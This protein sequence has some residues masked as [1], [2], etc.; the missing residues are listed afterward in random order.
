MTVPGQKVVSEEKYNMFYSAKHCTGTRKAAWS[1]L[2]KDLSQCSADSVALG[3]NAELPQM[4]PQ[5]LQG[6]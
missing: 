2:G 1:Q 6:W 4:L 5:T 3:R